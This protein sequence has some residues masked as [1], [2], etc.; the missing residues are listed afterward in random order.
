MFIQL[1]FLFCIQIFAFVLHLVTISLFSY[2]L[3]HDLGF[4]I[5]A[6][7]FSFILSLL[8][9]S[10]FLLFSHAH[11]RFSSFLSL[12]IFLFLVVFFVLFFSFFL[13][14]V[15][16]S[17]FCFQ[18]FF[19]RLVH[20]VLVVSVVLYSF[21]FYLS[22]HFRVFLLFLSLTPLFFA[23]CSRWFSPRLVFS[24]SFSAFNLLFSLSFGFFRFFKSICSPTH[25]ILLLQSISLFLNLFIPHP[26]GFEILMLCD[27]VFYS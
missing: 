7:P 14:S 8:F 10:V 21:C 1:Y 5:F 13:L 4:F 20:D 3:S 26:I 17:F 12:F 15:F 9:F 16:D 18:L 2:F 22:H 23:F 24:V 11:F 19:L 25:C 27:N 6:V